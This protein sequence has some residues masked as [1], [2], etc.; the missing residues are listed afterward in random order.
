MSKGSRVFGELVEHTRQTFPWLLQLSHPFN[1]L[2]H[3]QYSLTLLLWYSAQKS[4]PI[5]LPEERWRPPAQAD[6]SRK[7]WAVSSQ[8]SAV[9]RSAS[10][11]SSS[12]SSPTRCP[13]RR[14]CAFLKYL[15]IFPEMG[16]FFFHV[17]ESE[18]KVVDK[19]FKFISYSNGVSLCYPVADF[20]FCSRLGFEFFI[21]F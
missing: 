9:A 7:G 5:R 6:T 11:T 20:G 4:S 21:F 1:Y 16:E 3:A 8:R 19:T 13:F 2:T 14:Q 17:R 18:G 15:L 10:T 12:R